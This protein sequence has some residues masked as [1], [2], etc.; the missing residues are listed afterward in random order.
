MSDDDLLDDLLLRWE[1]LHDQ[2]RDVT[3]E[4]LCPERPD[5]A[6]L[7]TARIVALEAVAWVKGPVEDEPDPVLDRD[8]TPRTRPARS[9]AATASTGC[10]ARAASP[11]CG[12][13]STSNCNGPSP[14]RFPG[15]LER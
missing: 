3:A 10:S 4:E 13:G 14:S 2:G 12:R 6:E 5:L 7:L 1:E 11:R 8:R 15:R 9:P